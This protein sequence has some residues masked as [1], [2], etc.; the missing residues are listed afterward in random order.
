[1]IT[2]KKCDKSFGQDA[3]KGVALRKF[4]LG[5]SIDSMPL[6]TPFCAESVGLS[7]DWY[8][9]HIF[10]SVVVCACALPLALARAMQLGI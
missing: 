2:K 5:C 4:I 9:F 3:C 6:M 10:E 8:W 7:F 1:M